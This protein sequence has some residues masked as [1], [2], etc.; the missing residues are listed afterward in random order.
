LSD[1]SIVGPNS[2]QQ[3]SINMQQMAIDFIVHR[4]NNCSIKE[5]SESQ[6]NVIIVHAEVH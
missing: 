6:P 3:N 2:Q 5:F 1:G 4:N